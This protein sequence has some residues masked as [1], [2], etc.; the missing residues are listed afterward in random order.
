MENSPSSI[1]NESTGGAVIEVAVFENLLDEINAT[2]QRIFRDITVEG[3]NA[4]DI[5]VICSDDKNS[6]TYFSGLTS[7]LR[8]LGIKTVNL[9]NNSFAIQDFFQKD[10][11]TLST[12]YKAKGNEAV[13]VFVMGID[14]LFHRPDARARNTIFTAMTRAKGWLH[15]SGMGAPAQNFKNEVDKALYFLPKLNFTFPSDEQLR[16]LK[17]DLS[18]DRDEVAAATLDDLEQSMG[19]EE[20]KR[21]LISRLNGLQKKQRPPGTKARPRKVL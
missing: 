20:Y 16:R 11:V 18:F 4:D 9:Q 6:R 12:V 2:A 1:S 3:L 8:D 14:A 13:E 10:H 5:L 21:L 7:I 17:R 19:A 15:I